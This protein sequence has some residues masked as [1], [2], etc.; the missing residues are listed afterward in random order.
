[1]GTPLEQ[2]EKNLLKQ[3]HKLHY[4]IGVGKE[5]DQVR[6]LLTSGENGGSWTCPTV[7]LL[8]ETRVYCFA[9]QHGTLGNFLPVPQMGSMWPSNQD[10]FILWS[11]LEQPRV[12]EPLMYPSVPYQFA[13]LGGSDMQKIG[14][15]TSIL[16]RTWAAEF[17][18]LQF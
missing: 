17:G 11:I 6:R 5:P 3:S 4:V 1:M 2:L 18:R 13:L 15:S 8:N 7:D 16:D 10:A 14:N 12:V 9:V